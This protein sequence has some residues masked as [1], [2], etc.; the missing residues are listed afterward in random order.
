MPRIARLVVPGYPHHVTQRGNRRQTV[1]FS[2]DDYQ[3]YLNYLSQACE[4][5]SVE[6]WAY[7]LMPNH[8][9]MIAVP[10]SQDGLRRL[11]S[12]A[13]R[14][15]SRMINFRE[16]WRGHLWQERFHSFVMNEA[17]LLA[18]V[19]Y[20]ELNP[21]RARLCQS[22]ED[23][24]WSSTAAHLAGKDDVLVRVRPML[25]RVGNWRVYLNDAGQLPTLNVIRTHS[26]TGRPAGDNR[27][28]DKLEALTGR[29]LKRKKPGRKPGVGNR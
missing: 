18:A 9:H 26:R 29:S 24:P 7:C 6:I 8:I 21:V 19:R 11:F 28:I 4:N 1:F 23:W 10:E 2:D 22:A 17:Y 12:E 15:Y 25:D 16:G 20:V 13:H 14:R 27:F 3:S 5:A